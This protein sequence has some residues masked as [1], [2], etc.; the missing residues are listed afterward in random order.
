MKSLIK[1]QGYILLHDRLFW[2]ITALILL[3]NYVMIS[4]QEITTELF[5]QKIF[6][7]IVVA[8]LYA[9]GAMA[10][11]YEDHKIIYGILSG[12]SR[13]RLLYA[14]TIIAIVGTEIQLLIFP[15]CIGLSKP[16]VLNKDYMVFILIYFL[17]GLFL[18][19]AAAFFSVLCKNQ[20]VSI[21]CVIVFHLGSLLILNSSRIGLFAAHILPVGA[22][23]LVQGHQLA[24]NMYVLLLMGWGIMLTYLS[25]L[26]IKKTDF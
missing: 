24:L 12:N 21:G 17:L 26:C 20:G 23:K 5:A 10:K 2:T 7:T 13:K 8:S 3:V 16:D 4:G 1:Y 11:E 25:L 18:A 6:L 15:L 19:I 14:K 22:A 9:V